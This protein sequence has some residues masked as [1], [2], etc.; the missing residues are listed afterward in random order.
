MS[1]CSRF[2]LFALIGFSIA[3]GTRAAGSDSLDIPALTWTPRSDWVNVK[4]APYGAKGD[5]EADDTAAI[6][7]ALLAVADSKGKFSTVFL[8]AGTYKLTGPISWQGAVVQKGP[9][10]VSFIGCGRDTVI[11]WAGPKDGAMFVTNGATRCR[12]LGVAWDGQGIAATAYDHE[13]HMTYESRVRHENES[14]RHFTGPAITAFG[15]GRPG[16]SP[17]AEVFIWNCLFQHCATGIIVGSHDYNNYQWL[18]IGCEFDDCG[19]G[20]RCEKGKAM[21]CDTHFERSSVVDVTT[22]ASIDQSVRR[23]TSTG[24][25]AFFTLPPGG[26]CG[27]QVVEDCQVDSWKDTKGAVQLGGS[28]SYLVFDCVF[29][30]PPGD[31]AP[32]CVGESKAPPRIMVC[33]NHQNGL[34]D[35]KLVDAKGAPVVTIPPGA[36]G[37]SPITPQ[38]HFLK[39]KWPAD[40]THILDVTQGPYNLKTDGKEDATATI[41]KAIDDAKSANNGSIVYFPKGK[42]KISDT[43]KVSGSNYTLQGSGNQSILSW[44]GT[45]PGVAMAVDSPDKL[46]FEQFAIFVPGAGVAGVVQ[47]ATTPGQT[48]YD[49]IYYTSTGYILTGRGIE[50]EKLPAG[51]YVGIKHIDSP[52]TVDDSGP[53]EVVALYMLQGRLIVKGATQPK[54]GFLGFLDFDGL[55]MTQDPA[56]FDV[57]VSD[58]QNLVVAHYYHE[59]GYN[60]LHASGGSG[61]APGHVTIEGVKQNSTKP[62]DTILIDNYQGRILYGPQCFMNKFSE[63]ITQAGTNPCDL[64]LLGDIWRA[65]GGEPT[66]KMDTGGRLIQI[67]NIYMTTINPNTLKYPPDVIPDKGLESVA[68]GLDDLQQL[69]AEDLKW[70]YPEV[71]ATKPMP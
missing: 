33:N 31:G 19:T 41:Q 26:G 71:L 57:D 29:S 51:S 55:Q 44:S 36:R 13:P 46:S 27:P 23:C 20:I 61:T 54:T 9:T 65:D 25:A 40:S 45:S 58:N 38:T 62:S 59:Q 14:Y 53:A 28:G 4:D 10:G 2:L 63:R 17:T 60:H 67:Q 69:G 18:I 15:G 70:N 7:A 30:N 68:A 42:Y 32:I 52:L 16:Y 6:Q 22:P 64:I 34:T 5:G 47:T 11:K 35:D 12:Y 66:I 1:F 48:T 8:P 24:S 3:G 50:L 21:V 43:L 56:N 49:G 37:P 39:T